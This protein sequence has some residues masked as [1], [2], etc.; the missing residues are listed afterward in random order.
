MRVPSAQCSGS[1]AAFLDD[2][3]LVLITHGA[4]VDGQL[5]NDS[6]LL[7]LDYGYADQVPEQANSSQS[8]Y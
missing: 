6:W 4:S 3:N 7:D 1:I 2:K 5:L 8:R